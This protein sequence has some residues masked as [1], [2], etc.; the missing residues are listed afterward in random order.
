[1]PV[2]ENTQSDFQIARAEPQLGVC[3]ATIDCGTQHSP[4]SQFGPKRELM[5]MWELPDDLTTDGKPLSINKKYTFSLGEKANL[6]KDVKSWLGKAP[7]VP[8]DTS[9]LLGRPCI[10]NVVHNTS[11]EKVYANVGAITPLM[12][13][14]TAAKATNELIDFSLHPDH[15]REAT[16]QKLPE[17]IRKKIEASPEYQSLGKPRTPAGSDM[18]GTDQNIPVDAY[19]YRA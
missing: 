6:Y 7:E 2:I 17:W 13:G 5:L 12:K 4:N 1:M 3:Y 19:E 8:F 10:L 16:F 15:Y 18:M 11:G 9:T 14:M